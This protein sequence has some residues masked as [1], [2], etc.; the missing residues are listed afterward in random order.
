MICCLF[1]SVANNHTE[2]SI[3]SISAEKKAKT[4]IEYIIVADE[5]GFGKEASKVNVVYFIERKC[6][7]GLQS[8]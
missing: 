7:S 4:I 2:Y 6:I 8:K 5:K 3:L 1:K